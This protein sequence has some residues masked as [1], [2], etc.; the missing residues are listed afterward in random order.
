MITLYKIYA[1]QPSIRA[2]RELPLRVPMDV[3]AVREP[4][5]LRDLDCYSFTVILQTLTPYSKVAIRVY[6][7]DVVEL[8]N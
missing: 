6:P 2:I 7:V 4:P 5:L 1:L 8:A 3:G